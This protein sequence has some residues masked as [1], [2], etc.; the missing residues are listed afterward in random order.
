MEFTIPNSARTYPRVYDILR[1]MP[2]ALKACAFVYLH[3]VTCDPAWSTTVR[4]NTNSIGGQL[5]SQ[6]LSESGCRDHC[7]YDQSGCVAVDIDF[8][9][10]PYPGCWVHLN[11]ANLNTVY[12]TTGVKQYRLNDTYPE[13]RVSTTSTGEMVRINQLRINKSVIFCRSL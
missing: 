5:V 7:A 10:R 12:A 1:A 8:K 4:E 11:A 9:R 6:L 2:S 3:A 13:C